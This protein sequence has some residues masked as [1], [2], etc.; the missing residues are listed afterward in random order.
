MDKEEATKLLTN[1]LAEYRE[2]SYDQLVAKI[3]NDDYLEVIGASGTEYQI[4][5]QFMWDRKPGGDVRVSD[6]IDD[7]GL[8]AFSR[9]VKILSCRRVEGLWESDDPWLPLTLIHRPHIPFRRPLYRS[10]GVLQDDFSP[11]RPI[12]AVKLI[13]LDS[14]ND[15]PHR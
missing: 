4:E 2:L 8:R 1:K 10:L 13:W 3:G 15:T 12:D 7:G 14:L 5:V 9:C 11:P 6:G